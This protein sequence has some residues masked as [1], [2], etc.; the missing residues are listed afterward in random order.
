MILCFEVTLL[1]KNTLDSLVAK[2]SYSNYSDLL[3]AAVQNLAVLENAANGSGAL[4]FDP[5]GAM[6]AIMPSTAGP[7]DKALG[8][9]IVENG[10]PV[11]IERQLHEDVPKIFQWFGVSSNPPQDL[12]E[13]QSNQSEALEVSVDQ[14][15]WGQHSKL[16]PGKVSCRALANLYGEQPGGFDLNKV[17]PL[18]A[19]EASKLHDRLSAIDRRETFVRDEALVLGFPR[20]GTTR[21]KADYGTRTT[22]SALLATAA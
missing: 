14:W 13:V 8:R 2:G 10:S 9:T 12:P 6:L 4:I 17:A 16:L 22:T 20:R 5:P 15:L 18:I 3:A 1:T 7:D 21:I 19:S 11:G